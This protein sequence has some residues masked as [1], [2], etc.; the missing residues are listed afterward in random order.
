MSESIHA[1]GPATCTIST[2]AEHEQGGGLPISVASWGVDAM[3]IKENGKPTGRWYGVSP[4]RAAYPA[5]REGQDV[6]D[7]LHA[8]QG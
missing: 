1:A 7:L 3:P 5:W 4:L 6:L 2:R 8:H